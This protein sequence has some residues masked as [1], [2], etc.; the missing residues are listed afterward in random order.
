MTDNLQLLTLEICCLRSLSQAQGM[1]CC[2]WREIGLQGT[3]CPG[4]K[5]EVDQLGCG[6]TGAS[7]MGRVGVAKVGSPM[8]AMMKE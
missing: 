3:P 7:T 4:F 1:R 2:V 6:G 5:D 8:D